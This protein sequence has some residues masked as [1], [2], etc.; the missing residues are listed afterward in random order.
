M[1]KETDNNKRQKLLEKRNM[2]L[3]KLDGLNDIEAKP[4]LDDYFKNEL[5]FAKLDTDWKE[6]ICSRCG[7]VIGFPAI[8]RT[9]NKTEI[10]ARC[11]HDEALNEFHKGQSLNGSYYRG[12]WIEWK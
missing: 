11:S 6:K 10:C 1:V 5:E 8:S 12:E 7:E 4:I 9:D 3:K 2:I